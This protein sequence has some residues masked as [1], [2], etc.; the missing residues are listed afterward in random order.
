MISGGFRVSF[1]RRGHILAGECFAKGGGG[2]EE[3]KSAHGD[4]DDMI[5]VDDWFVSDR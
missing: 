5:F 4:V 3:R 1:R 2:M